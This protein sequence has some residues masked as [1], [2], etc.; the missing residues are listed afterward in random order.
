MLGS[1]VVFGVD[2]GEP[3]GSAAFLVGF[4]LVGAGAGM[5]LGSCSDGSRRSA[6]GS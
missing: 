5:F 3:F 2:W 6:S 1:L 4:A